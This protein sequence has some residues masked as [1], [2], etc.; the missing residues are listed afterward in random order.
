[1]RRCDFRVNINGHIMFN[2]EI[3]EFCNARVLLV[4]R[5]SDPPQHIGKKLLETGFS[6]QICK[7]RG[8][9]LWLSRMEVPPRPN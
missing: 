2:T 5:V 1:M 8:R 3:G 7:P 6:C 4:P 9:F